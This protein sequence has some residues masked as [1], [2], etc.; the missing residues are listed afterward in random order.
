MAAGLRPALA[1][2]ENPRTDHRPA[3]FDAADADGSSNW[4]GDA[5]GEP[6]AHHRPH[7]PAGA[8]PS[9]HTIDPEIF[10]EQE[11]EQEDDC[12]NDEHGQDEYIA[13]TTGGQ[14]E[15]QTEAEKETL[16]AVPLATAESHARA[17]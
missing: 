16:A 13:T 15:N 17:P 1:R 11:H 5:A 10:D 3:H 6:N 8:S 7:G 2:E 4:E 14:E 9:H 12:N